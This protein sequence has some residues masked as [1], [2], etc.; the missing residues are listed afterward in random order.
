MNYPWFGEAR[1]DPK[2]I[3]PIEAPIA[4]HGWATLA[5]ARTAFDVSSEV[6]FKVYG[7]RYA[8]DFNEKI[9]GVDRLIAERRDNE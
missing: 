2:I 5:E 4:C 6:Y 3:W 8:D 9:T 7:D 1:K